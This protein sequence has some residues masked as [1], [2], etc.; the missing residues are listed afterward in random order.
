ML[1]TACTVSLLGKDV[2]REFTILECY[3]RG[4]L[5]YFTDA[6]LAGF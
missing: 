4:L 6:T 2:H 5:F 3:F 1:L